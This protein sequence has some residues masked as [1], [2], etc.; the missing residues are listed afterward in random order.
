MNS[1]AQR[2]REQSK[3][4][5]AR[6]VPHKRARERA[7]RKSEIQELRRQVNVSEKRLESVLGYLLEN[8][9]N[10]GC[11]LIRLLPDRS[12]QPRWTGLQMRHVKPGNPTLRK[13]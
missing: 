10:Y 4:R 5:S 11:K 6:H 3:L 8:A 7:E 2:T 9:P 12:Q 1:K 13:T